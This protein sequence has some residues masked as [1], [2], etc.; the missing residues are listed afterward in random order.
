MI[1]SYL[2]LSNLLNWGH[3]TEKINLTSICDIL[4]QRD[5]GE[6]SIMYAIYSWRGMAPSNT[7]GTSNNVFPELKKRV[8]QGLPEAQDEAQVNLSHFW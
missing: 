4:L 1:W 8:F 3:E 7:R 6:K 2:G 5:T